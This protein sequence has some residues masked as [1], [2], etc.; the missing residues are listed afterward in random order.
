MVKYA[1][2]AELSIVVAAEL[3]GPI[4]YPLGLIYSNRTALMPSLSPRVNKFSEIRSKPFQHL[5]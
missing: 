1:D 5:F 4:D 3:A 2:A